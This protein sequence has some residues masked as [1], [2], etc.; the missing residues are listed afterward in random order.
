MARVFQWLKNEADYATA[1]EHPPTDNDGS[2]G[3]QHSEGEAVTAAVTASLPASRL[4]EL[5]TVA[6]VWEPL[7][8]HILDD[9]VADLPDYTTCPFRGAVLPCAG[10]A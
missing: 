6:T 7:R 9:D 3:N 8:G 2:R 1:Q 10:L 5:R 4:S